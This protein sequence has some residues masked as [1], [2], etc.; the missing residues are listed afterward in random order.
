MCNILRKVRDP[1]T[2]EIKK[3]N[4]NVLGFTDMG[5]IEKHGIS[6]VKLKILLTM[7]MENNLQR[8]CY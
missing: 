2:T 7:L 4:K 3:S 5:D 8:T 1:I 6:S